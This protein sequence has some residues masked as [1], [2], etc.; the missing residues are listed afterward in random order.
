MKPQKGDQIGTCCIPCDFRFGKGPEIDTLRYAAPHASYFFR[1]FLGNLWLFGDLVSAAFATEAESDAV[2]RTTT[3]ITIFNAGKTPNVV[4]G[5]ARARVNHRLHSYDNKET[6]LEQDRKIIK[7]ERV[8]IETVGYIP[9]MAVSPYSSET[10]AFQI[11]AN[12]ALEVYPTG[13]PVSS[14]L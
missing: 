3:A 14:S 10:M 8:K 4:P 1:L 11:I 12:S 6:M 5:E 7:D 9:P 2:Q 13:H